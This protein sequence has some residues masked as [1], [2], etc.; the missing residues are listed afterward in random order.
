M[1]QEDITITHFQVVADKDAS[2]AICQ[3]SND[4]HRADFVFEV[5]EPQDSYLHATCIEH[6]NDLVVNRPELKSVLLNTLLAHRAERENTHY[7]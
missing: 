6:L 2:T 1:N 7:A 4:R 5:H 3:F